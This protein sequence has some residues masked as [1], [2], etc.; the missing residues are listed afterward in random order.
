VSL[1]TSGFQFTVQK[2]DDIVV[3]GQ[4]LADDDLIANRFYFYY[5][6]WKNK[7]RGQFNEG[8]YMIEPQSTIADIV[9]KLTTDGQAMIKVDQDIDVLFPE[10]WSAEKM[11][12]RLNAKG[13]PGEEFQKIALDPPAELIKST[14]S[15]HEERLLKDIY[16]QTHIHFCL[17]R[18]RRKLLKKCWIILTKR[19]MT[20]DGPQ[21]RNMVVICM[22]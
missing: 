5:Y 17:L 4:K 15:L 18:Q 21:S 9:Y 20:A 22:M 11:K 7:L 10:G 3:I 1:N 19:L 6:A 8:D 12:D 16:F 13:L 14:I 2:G